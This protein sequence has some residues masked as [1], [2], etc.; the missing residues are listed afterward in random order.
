MPD[1]CHAL[2]SFPEAGP[3]IIKTIADWK[4]W[5]A[6]KLKIRWQRDFFEHRIRRD[7]SGEQKMAYILEN[8]VRA[9]LVACAEEWPY[10]WFPQQ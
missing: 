10:V 9:K 2:L 5:L 7:E 8:P 3:S 6:F 4:H 1:H